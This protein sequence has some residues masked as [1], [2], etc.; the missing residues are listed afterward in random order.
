MMLPLWMRGSG[1]KVPR[2]YVSPRRVLGLHQSITSDTQQKSLEDTDKFVKGRLFCRIQ[3]LPVVR[4]SIAN[5][6]ADCKSLIFKVPFGVRR[7]LR[8]NGFGVRRLL[9]IFHEINILLLGIT[10]MSYSQN[11]QQPTTNVMS[12]Y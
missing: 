12:N 2:R 5:C 6:L 8:G 4:L 10:R 11:S 1:N 9:T 3:P 7:L